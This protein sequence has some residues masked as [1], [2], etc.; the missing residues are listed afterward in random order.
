MTAGEFDDPRLPLASE[1]TLLAW[2]RTSLA[3]MGFGFV[4]A[5]FSLF[6]REIAL[7]AHGVEPVSSRGMSLWFGIA[8]VVLGAVIPLIAALEHLR[9]LE[10][11]KRKETYRPRGWWPAVVAAVLITLIGGLL[12]VYLVFLAG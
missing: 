1:R 5:R 2:I 12:A 7:A 8:F 9:F 6:L 11:L 4:V 10:R 3:M